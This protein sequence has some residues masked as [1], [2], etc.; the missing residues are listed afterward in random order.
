MK[1]S[2]SME[3]YPIFSQIQN[4]IPI[5]QDLVNYNIS[6]YQNS[7]QNEQKQVLPKQISSSF[8]QSQDNGFN[9]Y[10]S[11]IPPLSQA[12]L[13]ST[14][15]SVSTSNNNLHLTKLQKRLDKQEEQLSP[16][17]EIIPLGYSRSNENLTN[18]QKYQST[19]NINPLNINK[20][21]LSGQ[22]NILD[23][24]NNSNKEYPFLELKTINGLIS[25]R[26]QYNYSKND[27]TISKIPHPLSTR[28]MLSPPNKNKFM[29]KLNQFNNYNYNYNDYN[30]INNI[31]KINIPNINVNNSVE[32]K[33]NIISI[34][35]N[36]IGLE[37]TV[38][39]ELNNNNHQSKPSEVNNY[40]YNSINEYPN[41]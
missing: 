12:P 17:P 9:V 20:N 31:N 34:S 16:K 6:N 24:S 19:V 14:D 3:L 35:K 26:G 21:N 13:T 41:T 32:I 4:N 38:N 23:N 7:S 36:N 40:L 33:N 22:G 30:N 18:L 5:E 27:K 15:I 1:V 37:P 11:P 10:P 2:S 28:N 29:S 8:V 39:M 25:P